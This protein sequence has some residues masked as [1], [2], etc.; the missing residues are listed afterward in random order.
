MRRQADG[1]KPSVEEI[2]RVRANM[3]ARIIADDQ[4]S[5]IEKICN[6][7]QMT[8]TLCF[9]TTGRSISFKYDGQTIQ[10]KETTGRKIKLSDSRIGKATNIL[11]YLGPEF[12]IEE[13]RWFLIKY[14]HATERQHMRQELSGLP[15]WLMERLKQLIPAMLC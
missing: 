11:W 12:P 4:R 15:I 10:F 3:L 14:L 6:P 13:A 5:A 7:D 2:S 9:N 1:W 8:E